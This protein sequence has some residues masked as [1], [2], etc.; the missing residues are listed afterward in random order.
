VFLAG[1]VSLA[2]Q[3]SPRALIENGHFKRARALAEERFRSDPK[4]PETLWL[5][6]SVKQ[7][8]NDYPAAIDAA[9]KA[10]AADP[11]SA[12]Y[13]M[14]LAD[15]LSDEAMKASKIHA[16]GFAHRIKKE[17]ETALTLDPQNVEGLRWLMQ[18]YLQAP[19]L[20]GGDKT[21]ARAIPDQIMR[22]DPVEGYFA[23]IE[24]ARFDKQFPLVEGLYR[25][26]VEARPADY[27]A[28]LRLGNFCTY[29]DIKK[30]EEAESHARE[31]RRINP[32]RVA[33]YN[34][35]AAVL[36]RQGKW[37]ELDRVLADSEKTIP[38]NLAPYFHA[39]S[40]CVS[41]NQEL[42]RAEQYIRKYLGQE[43]EPHMPG[44]AAAHWRLGQIMEKQNRKP[45]AISEYQAA[46]KID[47][48]SPAK[49]D[50]KRLK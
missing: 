12:R 31:A 30:Y 39:A 18:Y 7:A 5:V 37:T 17:I 19:S 48:N 15:A 42:P 46:L 11:K 38:D 10:V 1:A 3:V 2:A 40:H 41:M 13:H 34:L 29:S 6:S 47:P 27:E 35:L 36:V 24:L 50:L 28:Q 45:E 4:D 22:I 25:K 20:F 9:E 23:Q 21:K 16:L 32:D 26:A 49:Q 43:P 44:H 14:R 33:A 8:W